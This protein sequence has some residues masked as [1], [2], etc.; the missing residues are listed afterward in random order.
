MPPLPLLSAILQSLARIFTTLFFD[1]KVFGLHNLP[2][3]GPALI[4][5]IHQGTIDP[6]FLGAQLHRPLSFMAKSE[7]FDTPLSARF[8][9]ALNTDPVRQGAGDI[10]AIKETIHRLQSGHL[11]NIFP[12]GSRSEDGKIA[13]LQKGI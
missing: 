2:R 3:R 4:V 6:L 9:R 10:S 5:S 7:L 13:P 8:F 11:L 1:L 12:E